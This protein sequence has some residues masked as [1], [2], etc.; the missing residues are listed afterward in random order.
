VTPPRKRTPPPWGA[1]GAA[2]RSGGAGGGFE[3]TWRWALLASVLLVLLFFYPIVMGKVFLSPDA[4]APAGFSKIA[5]EALHERHVYPLWNPYYFLGMP[6][7][8]SLAY[9]PYVYPPD[10]LFGLLNR[11]GFPDLT[12]LL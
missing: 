8:G 1:R 10:V 12:W 7:F 11:I 5:N 3:L 9:A 4:V 6:S 2:A